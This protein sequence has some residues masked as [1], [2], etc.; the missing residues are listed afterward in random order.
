MK[1][2]L[3]ATSSQDDSSDWGSWFATAWQGA[4]EKCLPPR[5]GG[6]LCLHRVGRQF[7]E[8]EGSK[9][10]SCRLRRR[11]KPACA[12]S[13][14]K[15]EAGSDKTRGQARERVEGDGTEISQRKTLA[16]VRLSQK[17]CGTLTFSLW[18]P[19]KSHGTL[20]LALAQSRAAK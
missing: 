9:H 16:V 12:T 19:N 7:V 15:A 17:H 8:Q 2:S 11:G 20:C 14:S 5:A 18:L 13:A 4:A 10:P 6:R 1:Q 3:R